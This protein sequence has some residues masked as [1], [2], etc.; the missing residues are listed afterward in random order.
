MNTELTVFL[1]DDDPAVRRALTAS[2]EE[3]QMSVE[4]Y[5]SGEAFLKAY[6]ADRPGCL[7]LDIKMPGMSGLELQEALVA[8]HCK[9]PIIFITG[10]GDVPKAVEA[11]KAG[12]IDFLEKPYRQ[13]VLLERIEEA[14]G[15]SR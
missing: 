8:K 5:S 7:V 12:A 11:F 15:Q 3:R 6:S 9:I 10:H 1:V 2:L 13:E 14:L 4:S